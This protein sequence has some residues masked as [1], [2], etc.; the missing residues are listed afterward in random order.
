M[1]FLN[2]YA[3]QILGITR[4]VAG[5]CFLQHG[6]QK[7]L[8]FPLAADAL[9]NAFDPTTPSGA[10]GVIELVAGALIVLGFYSR[11][12]AFVASG[13]MACAYFIAHFPQNFFPILNRG[14]GA[15]L[16]CFIFLVLAAMGP[17]AFALNKK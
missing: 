9:P 12:A 8:G 3:S 2:K 14:E 11:P 7:I 5:L 17:G 6:T 15:I 13:T 1:D 4:I 10:A 16:Y